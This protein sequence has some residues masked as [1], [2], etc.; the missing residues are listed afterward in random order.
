[1]ADAITHTEEDP[2]E[3]SEERRWSR[4]DPDWYKEMPSFAGQPDRVT[5][6][7]NAIMSAARDYHARCLDGWLESY[8]AGQ[9]AASAILAERARTQ[10]Y[11]E[12]RVFENDLR[13][14]ILWA[15][16]DYPAF[17]TRSNVMR[18][19]AEGYR[20][21]REAMDPRVEEACKD[22][23][24]GRAGFDTKYAKSSRYYRP[25]FL[26]D[27]QEGAVAIY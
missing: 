14:A 27:A 1:M 25:G 12:L 19:T 7:A 3:D 13:E 6:L 10:D 2:H 15:Y 23:P 16:G 24:I 9:S 20:Q 22:L 26:P 5:E 4:R 11:A 18:L 21:A 8:Q 17:F